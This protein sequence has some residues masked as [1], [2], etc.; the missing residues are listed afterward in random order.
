MLTYLARGRKRKDGSYGAGWLDHLRE[1]ALG[2]TKLGESA[3]RSP[4][5]RNAL[6]GERS[7]ASQI[8]LLP[9]EQWEPIEG[10]AREG[11]PWPM[12]EPADAEVDLQKARRERQRAALQRAL[13]MGRINL[14]AAEQLEYAHSVIV[15]WIRDLCETRKIPTPSGTTNELALWLARNVTA[16]ASDEGAAVC[17]REI[18]QIVT[19]IERI[20]NRPE[21][22]RD[23]GPCPTVKDGE[24]CNTDLQARRGD[25]DVRCWKCKTT[26]SIDDLIQRGLD[27]VGELLYCARDI[28]AIMD[29][30]GKH[31][32]DR[33]WRNWRAEK[34]LIVRGWRGGEPMYWISDVR[35]LLAQKPQKSVTGRAAKK[36]G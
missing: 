15:E 29:G 24:Q 7:L 31:I 26:Y 14:R 34:R 30:I 22:T 9:G 20:I 32:P 5:Y 21:S 8:D 1:S 33:T 36:A 16:I 12:R 4:R 13:G 18:K 17:Y 23:C 28:L 19:D 25:S 6:D 10:P 11:D 35:E 27:T 3:R 2:Q